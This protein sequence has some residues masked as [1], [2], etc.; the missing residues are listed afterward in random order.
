MVWFSFRFS[1][2]STCILSMRASSHHQRMTC[3]SQGSNDHSNL[4]YGKRRTTKHLCR[5]LHNLFSKYRYPHHEC[6]RTF[7][8]VLQKN[9]QPFLEIK[10]ETSKRLFSSYRVFVCMDR[11]PIIIILNLLV[12]SNA[13]K[14]TLPGVKPGVECLNWLLKLC[15]L[16]S[17]KVLVLW[18]D[19]IPDFNFRKILKCLVGGMRDISCKSH[20]L[21]CAMVIISPKLYSTNLQHASV[22]I[23]ICH[24]FLLVKHLKF[25]LLKI[26]C[27]FGWIRRLTSQYFCRLENHDMKSSLQLYG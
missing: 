20:N 24:R 3:A 6:W 7:H 21:R 16:Y 22:L 27:P 4:N 15:N 10:K 19:V 23:R 17:F 12:T 26:S 11:N 2:T 13:R 8:V 5:P 14:R 9:R 25:L 1:S 18:N